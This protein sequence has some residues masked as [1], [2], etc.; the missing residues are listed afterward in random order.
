Q[1][2]L[3]AQVR[4][5]RT[6]KGIE[7]LNK[8]LHAYFAS[9]GIK[10]QTSVSRTP[11][12]NKIV[13]RQN[14]TLVEAARTMLSAAKVPILSPSPQSQENVPQEAGTVTTSNELDLLFS[15]MFDEL[16]NG[17]TQVTSK[18]STVTTA[19]APNQCQL[20]HTTPLNTQTTPEPTCQDPIQA[21]TVTSTENINQA[22]TVTKNA[23]VEDDEFINIFC[24]PI[25]ERGEASSHLVDLSNMHTFYERHPL[26]HR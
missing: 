4:I 6:D 3:H 10:H 16:L 21:P 19:D 15:L 17:S 9:E 12:Q 1:R 7:F 18:S 23:Q 22:E 20:Q 14:R 24:T 25:Q 5:V 2:G 8:T 11:E 26:E 13:K